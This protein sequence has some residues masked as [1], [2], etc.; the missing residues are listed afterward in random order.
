MRKNR[1]EYSKGSPE[2]DVSLVSKT[3]KI[4]TLDDN[5]GRKGTAFSI[6]YYLSIDHTLTR[7][8]RVSK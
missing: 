2:H 5:M 3:P 1:N 8:Y 6:N 4:H 7:L